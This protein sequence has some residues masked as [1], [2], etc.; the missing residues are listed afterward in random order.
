MCTYPVC[1]MIY[2]IRPFSVLHHVPITVCLLDIVI[3]PCCP[4]FLFRLM[5]PQFS[6]AASPS[7]RG[8]FRFCCFLS[9]YP[10]LEAVMSMV[11]WS[12]CPVWWLLYGWWQFRDFNNK[13]KLF[14]ISD[15]ENQIIGNGSGGCKH[16]RSLSFI[17]AY[18][19]IHAWDTNTHAGIHHSHTHTHTHTHT[20]ARAYW[21]LC[22]I[23]M[24]IR[25]SHERKVL[26]TQEDI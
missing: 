19:I 15:L 3:R 4:C 26:R 21:E 18:Y 7:W 2:V 11:T 22:G 9:C 6:V 16:F 13:P 23:I 8:A 20:S 24:E 1:M 12:L 14:Y 10:L 5:R 25:L 17:T